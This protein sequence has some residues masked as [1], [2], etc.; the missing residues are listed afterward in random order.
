MPRD[1]LVAHVYLISCVGLVVLK[2]WFYF[3]FYL[4]VWDFGRVF[5]KFVEQVFCKL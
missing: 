3:C 1:I 2:S 5:V 4:I